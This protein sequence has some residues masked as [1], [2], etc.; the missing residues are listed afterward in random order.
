MSESMENELLKAEERTVS[1][2]SGPGG[3]GAE[4]K[5]NINK[6]P[7]GE[8]YPVSALK[9]ETVKKPESWSCRCCE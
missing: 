6:Y 4:K 2:R 7:K 3:G 5:K 9:K 8:I 1:P